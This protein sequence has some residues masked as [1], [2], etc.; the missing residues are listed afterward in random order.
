MVVG[1]WRLEFSADELNSGRVTNPWTAV[2]LPEP[3]LVDE[4]F[5]GLEQIAF[6]FQLSLVLLPGDAASTHVP[7]ESE[8]VFLRQ[9]NLICAQ[10]GEAL[11]EF[12][13]FLTTSLDLGRQCRELLGISFLESGCFSL[14]ELFQGYIG[15]EKV[16][17]HSYRAAT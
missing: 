3:R 8:D 15:F 10:F 6:L 16:I 14:E 1:Y 12:N 5:R 11:L 7:L 2:G 17:G 9:Q 13:D 4:S